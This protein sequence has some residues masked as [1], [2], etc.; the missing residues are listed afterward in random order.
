MPLS[1]RQARLQEVTV[2]RVMRLLE[3]N[4]QMSQRELAQAL[5]LSLGGVNYCLR[6]LIDKGWVEDAQLP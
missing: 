4:P 3:D 1:S 2:F 6:A 5:G